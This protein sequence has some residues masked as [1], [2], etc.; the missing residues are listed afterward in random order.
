M[1]KYFFLYIPFAFLIC[2][3]KGKIQSFKSPSEYIS[4]GS[5]AICLATN[6]W[7]LIAADSKV[8]SLSANSEKLNDFGLT[9]K[10]HQKGNL[11]YA[12]VGFLKSSKPDIDLIRI[13]T[14][15]NIKSKTLIEKLNEIKTA[16][17]DS[18]VFIIND[19]R[20][21]N[22]KFFEAEILN[23]N[24][25]TL[26]FAS[27]EGDKPLIGFLHFTCK[28]TWDDVVY[29]T[30]SINVTS[31]VPTLLPIG[32]KD[33]VDS[34]LDADPSFIKRFKN[35]QDLLTAL[36]SYQALKTPESVNN[37]VSVIGITPLGV[38]WYQRQE[39]CK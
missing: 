23:K 10:V 39:S 13:I 4:F 16:I 12:V 26:Q 25:S 33:A 20:K 31:Q 3:C 7:I 11:I 2:A 29:L 35:P 24:V 28:K 34:I 8:V 5:T 6:Q 17:K 21:T 1:F 14:N 38:A 32:H 27:F 18:L 19:T 15:L 37:K 30:D 22:E 36:I 9:C